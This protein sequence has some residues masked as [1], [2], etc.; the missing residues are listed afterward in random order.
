MNIK[1]N[2]MKNKVYNFNYILNKFIF[3]STFERYIIL[4]YNLTSFFFNK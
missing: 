4:F 3:T 2:N 1:F